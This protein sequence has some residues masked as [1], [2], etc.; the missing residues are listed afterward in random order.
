MKVQIKKKLLVTALENITEVSTKALVPDF[1]YNGLAT[2]EVRP[3]EV[4][5]AGSNGHL[6]AR[7]IINASEDSSVA[8]VN[9]PGIATVDT[10]KLRD[11]VR[12]ITT[13]ESTPVLLS[14]VK[15]SLVI[16]DNTGSRKKKVK[17]PTYKYDHPHKMD[18]K[19]PTSEVA[20]VFESDQL[21]DAVKIIA[22]FK[23]RKG[24]K[25]RYQMILFHWIKNTVRL[26]CG[27]GSL[28]AIYSVPK[29]ANDANKGET[30]RLIPVDQ[31]QIITNILPMSKEVTIFWDK[32]DTM[33]ME[34]KICNSVFVVSR[35]SNT[36][37]TT[38]T[39]SDLRKLRR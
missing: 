30:Q 15:N 12:R 8:A 16:S 23:S 7:Y 26:V 18:I 28:F 19:R 29:H 11:I 38:T 34:T 35:M 33:Y 1:N 24:F 31:L 17:L 9:E 2:I 21:I 13:D 4:I 10:I 27:D 36:S 20:H 25:V 14:L 3:K 5:F 39:H 32:K 37:L 22:P 6:S